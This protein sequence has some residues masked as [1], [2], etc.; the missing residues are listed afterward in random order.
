MRLVAIALVAFA[1]ACV[2][3]TFH[4]TGDTSCGANGVC[5]AA[6]FCAYTD[7][8]CASGLRY[9]DLSSSYSGVCVGNEPGDGG[10]DGPPGDTDGDGVPDAT[11]NCPTVPNANQAD[12]DKDGVGD[13]CQTTQGGGCHCGSL[14]GL[15][16][17]LALAALVVIAR[18]RRRRDARR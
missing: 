18:A 2:P 11:D 16:S 17:E 5:E 15:E 8:S 12:A 7:T 4:C 13:A 10:V 9:G 1:C 6:G 14:G 3:S